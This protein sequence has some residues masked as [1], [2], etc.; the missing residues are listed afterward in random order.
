MKIVHVF[1]F[2]FISVLTAIII[3]SYFEVFRIGRM[4]NN[5]NNRIYSLEIEITSGIHAGRIGEVVGRGEK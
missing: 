1:L 3:T 4:M 2:M 5:M